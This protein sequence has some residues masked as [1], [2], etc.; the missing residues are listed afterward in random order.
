MNKRT[1]KIYNIAN[2]RTKI[3]KKYVTEITFEDRSNNYLS[4]VSSSSNNQLLIKNNWT[5]F[6]QKYI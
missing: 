5:L 4:S 3:R 6:R 2:K 1:E